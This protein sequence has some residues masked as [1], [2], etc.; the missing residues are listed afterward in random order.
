M[1]DKTNLLDFGSP[2]PGGAHAVST[3]RFRREY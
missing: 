2:F 3:I 1:G